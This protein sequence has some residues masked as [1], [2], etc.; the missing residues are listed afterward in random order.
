MCASVPGEMRNTHFN[1]FCSIIIIIFEAREILFGAL[2]CGVILGIFIFFFIIVFYYCYCIRVTH[3]GLTTTCKPPR[4]ACPSTKAVTSYFLSY[5]LSFFLTTH[6]N[7]LLASPVLTELFMA[8]WNES[9]SEI[10]RLL[11]N[12]NFIILYNIMLCNTIH[13]AAKSAIK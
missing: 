12:R 13:T 2:Y 11:E 8:T 6:V 7:S 4:V 5:I 9:G 10:C 3:W 1:I